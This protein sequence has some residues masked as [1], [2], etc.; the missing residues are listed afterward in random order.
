M[1][2]STH[3]K[4]YFG[5]TV[6][7]TNLYLD[8]DEGGGELTATLDVGSYSLEEFADEIAAS[9]TAAG[10]QTYSVAVN[11]TTR[12]LTIS[13][14]G[15][16]TLLIATGSHLGTSA[17]TLAGFTGSDTGSATSHAGNAGSGSEYVTQFICQD[18]VSSDDRQNANDGTV[19]VS[20]SG[21]VQV[22]RFGTKKFIELNLKYITDRTTDGTII[23]NDA[24][25][26]S[27]LRTF[28]QYL[29]TKGHCEFMPDEDTPS[30]YQTV[31]LESTEESKDGIGYRLKE[32]KPLAGFFETG[33]LVF[34]VVE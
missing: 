28:M 18:H 11:R 16:F 3:S 27:K 14:A 15:A 32:N 22:V 10:G 2:L 12:V 19:L 30:T 24:S 34:R 5:H 8:F 25:G 26:V 4:W 33:K 1:S 6:D 9:M 29:V 23:R 20:A 21:R 7:D 17:F 13:A 31:L